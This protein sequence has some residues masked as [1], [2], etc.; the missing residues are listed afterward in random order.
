[1]GILEI[2]L[3]SGVLI[4]DRYRLDDRLATGGMGDV[5]RA[6]DTSLGR[7][8]AV[9]I[10]LPALLT[11]PSFSTRFRSE[12]RMLAALHHPGVVRVYDYGEGSGPEGG[13]LAYLVMEYVE[14]EPLSDL[15]ADRGRLSPD[16]TLAI[17][18]RAADALQAAHTA[19]IVHRDVKPGNLLLQ[20]DGSVT[21][22]DFGVARSTTTNT[23][24]TSTNAI[25]GTSLYMAPEQASGKNVSPATDIY[26]LGAV[27]YHCLAGHPP[28]PGDNPLEVAVRHV[29]AEPPSLPADVPAPVRDLVGR[30]LAKDPA[31]R[32]PTAAA[33]ASAARA[34][35]AAPAGAEPTVVQAA[36]AGSAGA[37]GATAARPGGPVALGARP[38]APDAPTVPTTPASIRQG[39]QPNK[40]VM[41]VA[42]VVALLLL[43]G[44]AAF[45]L[46]SNQDDGKGDNNPP[47]GNLPPSQS[48]APTNGSEPAQQGGGGT[49]RRSPTPGRTSRAPA[50][51][52]GTAREPA[53]E[54]ATE[55][56]G[57]G[58]PTSLPT[59]LPTTILPTLGDGA[60][61][62]TPTTPAAAETPV[63][64]TE[65][66]PG[67]PVPA[68]ALAG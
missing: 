16:E 66:P 5:W 61:D 51:S 27:A 45:L 42:A 43:G 2:V 31:D 28:F 10:L 4:D 58:L 13:Q 29:T 44:L 6:T 1:L 12:A 60:P 15:L 52:P 22:V 17:V 21:L 24:L 32:F 49:T 35:A 7:T 36:I 9:K 38:A 50:A 48:S 25:I 37:A 59:E 63:G 47:A 11:D 8:V 68:P 65:P 18:A 56:G 14:G 40:A 33:L 67:T 34:V 62:A 19:G 46:L 20:A 30:A 54:T 53:T 57:A 64:G 39:R 3:S 23:R 41:A 55:T 26:A